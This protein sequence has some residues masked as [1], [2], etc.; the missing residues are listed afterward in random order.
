MY[1]SW[2]VVLSWLTIVLG[3]ASAL[4]VAIDVR[5]R[6]PP[7]GIMAA[8]WPLTALFGGPILVAFYLRHGRSPEGGA[9]HH[10]HHHHHHGDNHGGTADPS[11]VSVTKGSL[12]CGA[13][14]SLG[15][16]LAE[17][18]AALWPGILT[19][20]GYPG[21]WPDRIFAAWGLDFILAFVLGIVF[22]YY[23]IVPMQGLKPLQGIVAAVKADALSLI[24]W[25]VGM[26]GAMA[27]FH[28]WVFPDL[29]GARLIPAS[30][31]FW[32]A[33]QI[34]MGAGLLTA[35]PTNRMLIRHGIKEA[36]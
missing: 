34:A 22:Q 18:A 16:I 25:Q 12:H 33:M 4:W 32:L 24:S 28:F 27:I 15:D 10:H 23:A 30:P 1:P 3:V 19:F 2:L 36:M 13:G 31:P 8:V 6:P 35:W 11:A 26:Y 5:R 17:S 20:F 7:M 29:I 21:F 9:D 14:C